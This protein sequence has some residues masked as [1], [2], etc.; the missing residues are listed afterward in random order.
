MAGIFGGPGFI[1]LFFPGYLGR[2]ASQGRDRIGGHITVGFNLYNIVSQ[3]SMHV[4]HIVNLIPNLFAT[5]ANPLLAILSCLLPFSYYSAP[6]PPRIFFPVA[7]SGPS[8]SWKQATRD[9][10]NYC[11]YTDIEHPPSPTLFFPCPALLLPCL[12]LPLPFI[13]PWPFPRRPRRPRTVISPAFKRPL[14]LSAS[15]IGGELRW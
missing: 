6:I 10:P 13:F 11:T 1:V 7:C 2:L 9:H 15:W 8:F 14:Q 4:L 3:Q 5:E 12:S